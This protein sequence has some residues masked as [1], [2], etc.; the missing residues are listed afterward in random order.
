M[1]WCFLYLS[2]VL[3][4]EVQILGS[5]EGLEVWACGFVLLFGEMCSSPSCS[6]NIKVSFYVE[7]LLHILWSINVQPNSGIKMCLRPEL[8]LTFWHLF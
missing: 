1:G 7:K 6:T 4:E 2:L 3:C 5:M 8:K